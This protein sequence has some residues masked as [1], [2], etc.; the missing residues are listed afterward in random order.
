MRTIKKG[1]QALFLTG[2]F[3]ILGISG[4][5]YGQSSDEEPSSDFDVFK[6]LP[7]SLDD[8]GKKNESAGLQ[9]DL[10]AQKQFMHDSLFLPSKDFAAFDPWVFIQVLRYTKKITP[11]NFLGFNVDLGLHNSTAT[12]AQVLHT[13]SSQYGG[14]DV[15]NQVH[16]MFNSELSFLH[17]YVYELNTH[18]NFSANRQNSF[19]LEAG[20]LPVRFG[21]SF[22]KNPVSFFERYLPPRDYIQ[23]YTPLD[24]PGAKFSYI[25]DLYRLDILFVPDWGMEKT[26][27]DQNVAQ[28]ARYLYFTN[29][30]NVLSVKNSLNFT[31]VQMDYYFFWENISKNKIADHFGLGGEITL[32][33]FNYL[34]ASWQAMASNGVKHY[35]AAQKNAYGV[36]SYTFSPLENSTEQYRLESLLSLNY[37]GLVNYQISTGYYYNGF[38]LSNQEYDVLVRALKEAKAGYNSSNQVLSQS[39]MLFFSEVLAR[40]NVFSLSQHYLFVNI[41]NLKEQEIF[42]WGLSA[43]FSLEQF[44]LMP[45]AFTNFNV[46]GN[47]KI[48]LQIAANIGAADSIFAES[49]V[50]FTVNSGIQWSF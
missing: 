40:Y 47:T 2:F 8:N 33:L 42:T 9:I 4:I 23:E 11:W 6:E 27:T 37:N 35:T 29:P 32:R 25:H 36:E 39:S 5:L 20:I 10:V 45:V 22:Y 30:G 44:S 12:R 16:P 7:E 24:F 46:N 19:F 48:Y 18:I 13:I 26:G 1:A 14:S 17:F 43:F 41:V 15:M 28:I 50:A 31:A 34:N 21:N 38:G 3:L 49:P